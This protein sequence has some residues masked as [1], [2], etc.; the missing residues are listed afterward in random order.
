MNL[1]VSVT[2]LQCGLL[3]YGFSVEMYPNRMLKVDE[4]LYI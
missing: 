1:T 3:Q 2:A 4:L